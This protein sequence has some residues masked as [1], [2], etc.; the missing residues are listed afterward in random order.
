MFNAMISPMPKRW[1][2]FPTQSDHRVRP[3]IR[4]ESG[5]HRLMEQRFF[6]EMICWLVPTEETFNGE[7]CPKSRG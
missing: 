1:D 2:R 6:D 4:C 5:R 3:A 7:N